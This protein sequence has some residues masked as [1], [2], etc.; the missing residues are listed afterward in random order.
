MNKFI[1]TFIFF[2]PFV[3]FLCSDNSENGE[4]DTN[5]TYKVRYEASCDSPDVTMRIMYSTKILIWHM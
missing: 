1:L 4:T 3:L 5:K 2:L